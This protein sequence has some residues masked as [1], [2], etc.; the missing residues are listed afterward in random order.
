MAEENGTTEAGQESTQG[1]EQTGPQFALQGIYLKDLSFESPMGAKAFKEKLNPKV[2]QDISTKTEKL[3]EDQYEVTLTVT[4]A[5]KNDENTIYL[6]EVQQAGAFLIKGIEG[7]QL[8]QVLNTHCP[9]AL[10]PYAREVIDNVVVKGGF[11]PLALPP[12]NF[13]ALF[14]QAM[15]QAK[16]KAE[17]AQAGE[18][19]GA[20]ETAH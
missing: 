16:A 5:V 7:Q 2:N 1:T 10:F 19:A 17:D 4:V 8:A 3:D 13:D 6:A 12:I 18:G 15:M 14:A 9:A 11:P 20:A